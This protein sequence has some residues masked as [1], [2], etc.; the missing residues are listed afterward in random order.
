MVLVL[1]AKVNRAVCKKSCRKKR[2]RSIEYIN[3]C[4][5][6]SLIGEDSK[7]ENKTS[8]SKNEKKFFSS[9]L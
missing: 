6:F 1:K 4:V 2:N 9:I 8:T 5:D 7:K 3:Y